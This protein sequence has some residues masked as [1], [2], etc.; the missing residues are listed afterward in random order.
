MVLQKS[1]N[2]ITVL[3]EGPPPVLRLY[4]NV[5]GAAVSNGEKES[6]RRL[7]L[8][9]SPVRAPLLVSLTMSCKQMVRRR[10]G[11]ALVGATGDRR[12]RL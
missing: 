1:L 10:E 8:I 12:C 11:A 4:N 2:I 5:L 6:R 7:N 9:P 3:V